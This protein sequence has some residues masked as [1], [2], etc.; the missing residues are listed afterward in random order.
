MRTALRRAAYYGENT[1]ALPL[2]E[3][4]A[5]AVVYLLG[6]GAAARGKILDLR[7]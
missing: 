3:I 6:E 7:V 1:L 2:P 5:D 4:A